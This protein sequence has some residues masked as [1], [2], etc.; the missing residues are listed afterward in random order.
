[1]WAWMLQMLQCEGQREDLISLHRCVCWSRKH[2]DQTHSGDQI[3][4]SLNKPLKEESDAAFRNVYVCDAPNTCWCDIKHALIWKAITHGL[5]ETETLNHQRWASTRV[6]FQSLTHK[7]NHQMNVCIYINFNNI[8]NKL[9]IMISFYIIYHVYF[10]YYRIFW[11][12]HSCNHP[13]VQIRTSSHLLTFFKSFSKKNMYL[14]K[15]TI[16][17]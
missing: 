9:K 1:M 13:F 5:W 16:H 17:S 7:Q 15:G 11:G 12:N 4:T 10:V 8:N 2:L 3:W 6:M 14:T